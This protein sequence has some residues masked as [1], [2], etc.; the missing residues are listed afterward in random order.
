M[1][2][3]NSF[4]KFGEHL[5]DRKTDRQSKDR[6]KKKA[7]FHASRIK[8]HNSLGYTHLILVFQYCFYRALKIIITV[9]QCKDSIVF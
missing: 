3:K 5:R 1:C 2:L 9:V 4:E 7:I 6:Q 8:I